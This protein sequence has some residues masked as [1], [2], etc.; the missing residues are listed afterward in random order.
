MCR[1]TY[2]FEFKTGKI[3]KKFIL[4]LNF[5]QTACLFTKNSKYLA[6]VVIKG[7]KGQYEP[8]TTFLQEIY[9]N[10]DHVL[11]L[12]EADVTKSTLSFSLQVKTIKTL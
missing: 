10:L 11:T 1:K 7:L 4:L 3:Q 12:L 8:I 5:I 6:H 9:G 2:E